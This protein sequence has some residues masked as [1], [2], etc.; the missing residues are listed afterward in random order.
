MLRRDGGH[1]A[2]QETELFVQALTEIGLKIKLLG[3]YALLA[4][5]YSRKRRKLTRS[6][7][8]DLS[9]E[10]VEIPSGLMAGAPP[11]NSDFFFSDLSYDPQAQ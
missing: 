10:K 4:G 2:S 5:S 11:I 9:G 3:A 6:T 8:A 1:V 7:F